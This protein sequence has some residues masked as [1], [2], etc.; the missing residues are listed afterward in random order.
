M[1][2]FGKRLKEARLKKGMRQDELAKAMNLTQPSISQF[3]KGQR[4]PTPA[5]IKKFSEILEVP[6][7]FLTGE[8]KGEFE[9]AMLMRNIQGLSPGTIGKINE[10]I[11]LLKDSE[12]LKDIKK[13]G[14][15]ENE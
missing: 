3:E 10:Y 8:D 12:R 13:S 1:S 2:E 7:E 14:K 6:P 4:L 9:K 11:Q 5:N 15:G